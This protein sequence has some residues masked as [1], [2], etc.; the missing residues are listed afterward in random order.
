[1]IY[2][3]AL[4]E[5]LIFSNLNEEAPPLKEIEVDGIQMVVQMENETE[6]SIVRLISGDLNHYLD[7]RLQPGNKIQFT[8]KL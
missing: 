2:Y 7:Q 4:P 5:E 8:A 1:M 6:A 3:T